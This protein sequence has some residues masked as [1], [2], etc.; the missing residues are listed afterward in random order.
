MILLVDA[1]DSF[2][3]NLVQAF[4]VLGAE[5]DVRRHDAHTLDAA[6]ALRPRAIVLSPGP[7]HPTEC[8]LHMAVGASDWDVPVL[9]VCLGHQALAA[10]SGGR[11]V[12]APS[13]HHGEAHLCRHDGAGL[14]AGLPADL[15]VGRYHSLC[16]EE[17]TLPACWR[18]N[19]RT[20]DGVVMAMEHTRLPR[21]GV[22]FHPESILTPDGPRLLGNFLK[23]AR[24]S[25]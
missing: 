22:Q 18:V 11:V 21:W 9:G 19:A 8:A 20:P 25:P 12:H 23:L 7:G 3:Y 14:F 4:N 17:A 10:A 15:P 16:A 24:F 13:P 1:Y 6:R 2:T 5:V